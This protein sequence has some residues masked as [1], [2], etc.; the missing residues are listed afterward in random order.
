MDATLVTSLNKLRSGLLKCCPEQDQIKRV[1]KPFGDVFLN[2]SLKNMYIDNAGNDILTLLESPPISESYLDSV[3][4]RLKKS[5]GNDTYKQPQ[6]AR[7]SSGSGE[8]IAALDNPPIIATVKDS[9]DIPNLAYKGSNDSIERSSLSSMLTKDGDANRSQEEKDNKSKSRFRSIFRNQN[10]KDPR[11]KDL[12]GFELDTHGNLK[13][14]SK[15]VSLYDSEFGLDDI[16][17]ED[18]DDNEDLDAEANKRFFYMN[19]HLRE[20]LMNTTKSGGSCGETKAKVSKK[21]TFL[22]NFSLNPQNILHGGEARHSSVQKF[23]NSSFDSRGTDGYRNSNPEDQ[24]IESFINQRDLEPLALTN[25]SNNPRGAH[26]DDQSI[27][28]N[29]SSQS[30]IAQPDEDSGVS[31]EDSVLDAASS[32][33]SSLLYSDSSDAEF[34][35]HII[36]DSS[37][38]TENDSRSHG[39]MSNSIPSSREFG[40][41]YNHSDALVGNM[42]D[43]T[44]RRNNQESFNTSGKDHLSAVFSSGKDS[45]GPD[46][47]SSRRWSNSPQHMGRSNRTRNSL[48]NNATAEPLKSRTGRYYQHKKSASDVSRDH[49]MAASEPFVIRKVRIAR[50]KSIKSQLSSLLKKSDRNTTINPLEHFAAISGS[51]LEEGSFIELDVYVQS[52]KTYK[53]NPFTIKVL[54][55][56]SVFEVL[57]YALYCYTTTSRPEDI[58]DD[59]LNIHEIIN[60]NYFTLKIVDEDGEPFEDNFGVLERTLKIGTVSDNEVVICRVDNQIQFRSNEAITPLNHELVPKNESTADAGIKS[61]N[62]MES[63]VSVTM[64]NSKNSQAQKIEVRV[65]MPLITSSKVSYCMVKVPLTSQINDIL[66]Q[67]CKLHTLEHGRYYLRIS[68]THT[69]LDPYSTVASLNGITELEMAKKDSKSKNFEKSNPSKHPPTLQTIQSTELV[70]QL[71]LDVGDQFIRAGDVSNTKKEDM[72]VDGQSINK[73]TNNNSKKH[74]SLY[75][76]GISRQHS[77]TGNHSVT[78]GGFFR[79]KNSSKSSLGNNNAQSSNLLPAGSSYKDLFTGAYYKY[80]VWRR[81]QVSFINKHERTLAIDG[82]YIYI[83]PPEDGYHWNQEAGKTKSFHISQVKLAKKSKRVHEYFKIFVSKPNSEKRYYFE[84]ISSEECTE[85]VTRLHNL[86]GAYKMNHKIK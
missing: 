38:D 4:P 1:I 73:T 39:Y 25:N 33:G 20:S 6:K 46:S 57:G 43:F 67:C 69:L 2:G 78:T 63:S 77:L 58:D 60:P 5:N 49:L 51:N 42:M 16:I 50:E 47:L 18:D 66:I 24:M 79:N 85:I 27:R 53:R 30:S 35:Q 76:L 41:M 84:A 81:Q 61:R 28:H 45:N 8:F 26:G 21:A 72:A 36:I 70:T 32:Y 11:N 75:K 56:A 9:L 29:V 15:R 10:K 37:I 44:S 3:T 19:A 71:T 59:G 68:N 14:T 62:H 54:K 74:H 7:E 64:V 82:D 17:D 48:P 55:S 23:D 31:I 80:K 52:S 65:R 83:I 40:I 12:E 34:Q 22:D 13:P 86:L